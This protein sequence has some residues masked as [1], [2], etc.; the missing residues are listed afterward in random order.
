MLNHTHNTAASVDPSATDAP[1]SA[2]NVTG[3]D[4]FWGKQAPTAAGSDDTRSVLNDG[5]VPHHI[6]AE[7]NAADLVV[8]A[9]IRTL[10][11][12]RTWAKLV[13]RRQRLALLNT[14]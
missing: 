12:V 7:L 2:F 9:R 8:R 14:H 1:F 11:C 13:R 6:G 4:G 3:E 10:E 5:Q